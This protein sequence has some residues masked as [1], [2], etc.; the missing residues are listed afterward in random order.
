MFL[1]KVEEPLLNRQTD[2]LNTQ[3]NQFSITNTL[4]QSHLD[5]IRGLSFQEANGVQI[6]ASASEDCTI[7]LWDCSQAIIKSEPMFALRG[8]AGPI[9][10]L[11]GNSN[12]M[13]SAG[14]EG[15][16]KIWDISK[17]K[18]FEIYAAM[19]G[20]TCCIGNLRKHNETIWD[21]CYNC[22]NSTL[23]SASSDCIINLWNIVDSNSENDSDMT[24]QCYK[25]SYKVYD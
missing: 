14:C 25:Q 24:N 17:I 19:K 16:I 7:K 18:S 1:S 20:D 6:L 5:V 21:L 9:F 15:V 23:L 10:C 22:T 4:L 3:N 13:F 12:M 8:H 2:N 11:C